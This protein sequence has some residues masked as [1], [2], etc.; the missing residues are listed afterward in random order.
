MPAC[1][2][3]INKQLEL[4]IGKRARMKKFLMFLFFN[5]IVFESGDKIKFIII[6]WNAHTAKQGT[7]SN[8]NKLLGKII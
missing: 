6:F 3:P 2:K 7:V 5:N 1:T 4:F 8:S